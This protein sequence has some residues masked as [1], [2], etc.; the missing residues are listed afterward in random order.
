[1]LNKYIFNIKDNSILTELESLKKNIFLKDFRNIFFFKD[2]N[3]VK[4]EFYN[5]SIY[6]FR[7]DLGNIL[8]YRDYINHYRKEKFHEYLNCL[9]LSYKYP[10]LRK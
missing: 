2:S 1:M 5:K 10:L 4:M 7:V 3:S 6:L 8:K 9:E